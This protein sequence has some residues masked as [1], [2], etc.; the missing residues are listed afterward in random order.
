M[1][2]LRVSSGLQFQPQRPVSIK[3]YWL[4]R[5]LVYAHFGNGL[6]WTKAKG[7][8]THTSR[9]GPPKVVSSKYGLAQGFGSTFGTGASDYITA[10]VLPSTS[11]GLR[12]LVAFCYPNGTGGGG[13]GRFFQQGTSAILGEALFCAASYEFTYARS[14]NSA[15]N[16]GQWGIAGTT[17]TGQWV[18]YGISHDQTVTG[19]NPTLYKN[20]A[21]ATTTTAGASTGSYDTVNSAVYLGGRSDGIRG[22]D[23]LEGPFLVFESL[24][25]AVEHSTLANDP[26]QIAEYVVPVYFSTGGGSTTLLPGLLTNSQTFYSP[27]VSGGGTVVAPPLLSNTQTFYAPSVTGGAVVV[28]PPLLTNAQTFYGPSVTQFVLREDYERSSVKLADSSITGAGDSAVISIRPRLQESEVTTSVFTW[29]EPSARVDGVN[30]FKPTFHYTP[31]TGT[32]GYYGAPWQSTRKAH[33]SYDRETWTPFD[34]TTVNTGSNRIEF[35]HNTA[36]TQDTVYVGR[37]R[38]WSV[39]QCGDWV[40]DMASTYSFFVPSAAAV[41]Y[42]PT[43]AVSG[44]SAQSFI[45]DEYSDST[46]ELGRTIQET[47]LYCAEINDTSLTPVGGGAK[48]LAIIF[49]G[50]HAGEDH[51]DFVM[52]RTVEAIC[53]STT[54]AQTIR[55]EYR[56]LV[57]PMINASGRAGGGWRGSYQQG[58]GGI[59]DAN[60]H[61]DN[62][63]SGLEIVDKP[64]AALLTDRNS[65]NPDWFIDF[66]GTYFGTWEMYG[67]VTNYPLNGTFRTRLQTN[68]GQTVN[69]NGT[70]PSTTTTGYMRSLGARMAMTHESGDYAGPISDAAITTHGDAIAE[71]IGSMVADGLFL[72][73]ALP[74]LFTNSQT[75][76]APAVTGGTTTVAPDLF[77]N[78]NSFYSATV[79]PGGVTVSPDLVSNSPTFYG[80]VIE[81]G[82]NPPLLTNAQVFYAATI[83]QGDP[84]VTPP[85]LVNDNY[86]YQPTVTGGSRFSG[87]GFGKRR[88]YLINGK[89]RWLTEVELAVVVANELL[90]KSEVKTVKNGKIKPVPQEVWKEI[91]SM[92]ESIQRL[93]PPDDEDEDEEMMLLYA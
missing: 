85:L 12:S 13:L 44:Y 60:R 31:H 49:G 67:D 79:T 51:A 54:E 42:T 70:S 58:P 39:H 90:P 66:H 89:K 55:R 45:A 34:N 87:G 5:G 9:N 86:F 29:M 48:R 15:A 88:A 18:C 14:Y 10:P 69:E 27:V 23:G 19:T 11:N 53:G 62:A 61:F 30:G 7:W 50:V 28:A 38:Q 22:W 71:T 83:T 74:G 25:T 72:Q 16:I 84:V 37:G 8:Q 73:T 92:V 52:M 78:A 3:K 21:L 80:P 4:D 77:V 24:L 6:Y 36:F 59:D 26:F 56:I 63:S 91:S 75:F 82:V 35:S 68:S 2:F 76:Y 65:Q 43:S 20:G 41:A 40:A 81:V 64:R 47:P 57:Y 1:P 17:P 46:D 93:D 32:G 33:F